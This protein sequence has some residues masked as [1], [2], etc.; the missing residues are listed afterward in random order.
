M[1]QENGDYLEFLNLLPRIHPY[2][3]DDKGCFLKYK[4]LKQNKCRTVSETKQMRL[5]INKNKKGMKNILQH[6][7]KNIFTAKC[8]AA[9]P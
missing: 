5:K 8:F 9:K 4:A 6:K 3:T 1:P 2:S 7:H